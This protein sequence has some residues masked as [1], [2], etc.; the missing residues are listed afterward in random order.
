MSGCLVFLPSLELFSF[1][2]VALSDFDLMFLFLLYFI[3]YVLFL[4]L[5]RPFY[6]H[7]RQSRSLFRW[8]RCAEGMGKMVYRIYFIRKK[9]FSKKGE[10]WKKIPIT[11]SL[12]HSLKVTFLKVFK[13]I[14][15]HVPTSSPIPFKWEVAHVKLKICNKTV[16]NLLYSWW[17]PSCTK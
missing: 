6:S 13:Y 11:S 16:M 1:C 8:E 14:G 7:E 3:F 5:R 10:T 17:T 4:S 12:F 2:W 9:L 15:L